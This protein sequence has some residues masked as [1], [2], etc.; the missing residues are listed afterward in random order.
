MTDHKF[1]IWYPI[2]ELKEFTKRVLFAPV[3]GKDEI[4][5]GLMTEYQL[6]VNGKFTDDWKIDYENED[7]YTVDPSPK[8]WMPLPPRP[9]EE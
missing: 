7:G 3:R 9:G 1:G 2:E 6:Y 5:I 8:L 4:I